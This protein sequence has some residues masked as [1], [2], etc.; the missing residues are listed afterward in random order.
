MRAHRL[1]SLVIATALLLGAC[2]GASATSTAGNTSADDLVSIGAGLQGPS[3]TTASAYATGLTHV[4]ALAFD[5]SN[6]LWVATAGY[7]DDGTDAVYVV[8]ASGAT[9]RKVIA[10]Q[11]TPLGLLWYE[12]ALYVASKRRV[13]VY[14][15]FDGTRFASHS[16]ILTLPSGVGEVNELVLAPNGRLLL[17]VS[18]AC[19][20]CTVKVADSAAI[21]SFRPDGSDLRVYASRIRAA[22]GL[23]FFPGTS[24]LFVTMNQR[25][26]LGSNTPGDWLSVVKDGDD[27]QFP[28]YYGQTSATY[29]SEPRP[30]AE[31]DEHAA[32]SGVAIVT[33]ELGASVGTAALV[34]EWADGKVL[35]V[36]LRKNGSTYAG[37]V[38]AFV[39]GLKRPVPVIRHGSTVFVGDWATG[40]VYAISRS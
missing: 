35:R 23:T 7:D 13:D 29:E 20:H 19:D 2:A 8:G 26:D 18:A 5:D 28:S 12:G 33:G 37:T 22:V 34:A 14:R 4:A 11:H 16:T 32:A 36:A 40:K 15:G 10:S 9:P 24:D 3:G 31:L 17:G 6:R 1:V 21:L 25:D 39:T 27:W 38:H 30:V